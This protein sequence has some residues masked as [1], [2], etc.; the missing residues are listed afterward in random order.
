MQSLLWCIRTI[1]NHYW[2][3]NIAWLNINTFWIGFQASGKYCI[4]TIVEKSFPE[5]EGESN[6]QSLCKFEHRNYICPPQT[7]TGISIQSHNPNTHRIICINAVQ[8]EACTNQELY[9][10]LKL[11]MQKE[12]LN[13]DVS[14]SNV[15]ITEELN[16][17]LK[18]TERKVHFFFTEH[19][20]I[21][22]RRC[23]RK[24]SV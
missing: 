3:L 4:G 8:S 5:Q 24:M 7:C 2:Q 14:K 9:T 18:I 13:W 20:Q 12:N 1:Q 6:G 10:M 11:G 22:S 21:T 17:W 19:S 16:M 15:Q 23:P